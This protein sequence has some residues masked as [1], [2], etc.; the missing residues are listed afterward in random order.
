MAIKS[1]RIY[2]RIVQL[3]TQITGSDTFMHCNT[4][5]T[6]INLMFFGPYIVAY[7]HNKDLKDALFTFSFILINNVYMFRAGL[8][9]II[10]RYC[11]AIGVC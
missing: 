10:R 7:L 2:K 1:A 11:A 5:N 6:G 3:Y 9:L 8:L 4:N